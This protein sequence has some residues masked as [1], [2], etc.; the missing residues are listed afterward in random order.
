MKPIASFLAVTAM[1]LSA[2]ALAGDDPVYQPAPAWVDAAQLPVDR[3][4][5]P[6]LLY[7]DQRRIETGRLWT[8]ADR[9]IRIDNPQILSAVGTIVATW[10]PDKG[11]LIVH[12]VS[13]VRGGEDIDVLAQGPK[14][15]VLRRERQLEQ[16]TIDGARTATLA[17][18]GLRV[19]DILRVA[20]SVTSSDQALKQQVQA[21]API[22]SA[23]FDAKVGRV[24]ISWPQNAAIK[25][26]ADGLPAPQPL[27]RNGFAS[28]ELKVPL[29]E[30]PDM[31]EDA[32][33]RYRMPA[34]LQ[35]G[36]FAN[37]AE[38]S[39]VMS[40]LFATRG[41]IAPG[42]ALAAEVARIVREQTG[43][44]PRA[45]AALRLVQDQVS[46]LANGMAGGNYIPQ[47]PAE[48]WEKRF[49][50]CKAKSLLLLS[51]LREMGIEGE[52]AVVSSTMGDALPGL[53]PMPA[54]FDHVIVHSVIDGTDFWLD[55]TSSG[56]SLVA[57][58]N[59][60]DFHFALPLRDGGA[61]LLTIAQRPEGAFD[62]I[63]KVTFDHRAGLDVPALYDGE[64]TLTGP[65]AAPFRAM[66]GQA[67]QKTTDELLQNYVN[68]TLGDNRLVD[69]S[70][71]FVPETNS[72][73]IS[74]RG[75]MT[76]AWQ[77][78]RGRASRGF[79]LPSAGFEFHPDRSRPAWHD[80]PVAMP[81]PFADKVSLTV[82]LLDGAA[83]YVIEG[84]ATLDQEIAHVRLH[85][86]A[87][88]VGSRLTI[89]D[90][91][92]WPGGEIAVTDIAGE[93]A[94]AARLGSTELKLRAPSGIP[95]SYEAKGAAD[96]KRFASIESAYQALIAKQPDQA[97]VFLQR[98]EFRS[99]TLDRAGALADLDKVIALDPGAETYISRSNLRLELGQLDRAL[100]DVTSAYELYPS[101]RTAE[102]K[103]GIL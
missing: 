98:A 13:I 39:R 102:A 40:P 92:G 101:L 76:S 96:R 51:M 11:D 8:Y 2:P 55:G 38:V 89:E 7:D 54:V 49:G 30:R 35:A 16:R 1:V 67:S 100:A 37:W 87:A 79:T 21:V 70:I 22:P 24:R 71:A 46:Y 42:S 19:G 94:R 99:G 62:R 93:R 60:P 88:L 65:A 18:P 27:V 23:P 64:W 3:T 52:P 72:V 77:W 57:A 56:A 91:A 12:R 14:F 50:D 61:D 5:P 41:T 29:A 6:I 31:P 25:W 82:L 68:A 58:A 44:L 33:M 86:V 75:L 34:M 78:E 10:L 9:A 32:P 81:G 26:Q 80:I 20:Y 48:T 4:G 73:R 17:V 90:S 74:A 63:G 85:R 15:D 47:T 53:L 43:A 95:R 103:A 45:V 83:P 66:I 97:A 84:P 59:V 69:G 36:T 28:L